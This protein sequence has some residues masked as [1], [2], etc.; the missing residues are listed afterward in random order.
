MQKN[1]KII[2]LAIERGYHFDAYDNIIGIRG[3]II[4]PRL[5]RQ[6]YPRFN[7]KEGTKYRTVDVHKLKAYIL[8]GDKIFEPGI[9]IRHLN[10]IKTDWSDKNITIGTIS[11]NRYDIPQKLRKQMAIRATS[12]VRKITE[13]QREEIR[14]LKDSGYTLVEI[15]KKFGLKSKGTVSMIVNKSRCYKHK[16]YQ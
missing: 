8:F 11:E 4:R 1:K 5:N 2:P 9:E 16:A 10:G 7:I 3:G 12:F 15:A 13:K 14:S 6:G